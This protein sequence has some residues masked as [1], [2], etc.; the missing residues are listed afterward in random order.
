[1][2]IYDICCK[3]YFFR[4]ARIDADFGAAAAMTLLKQMMREAWTSVRVPVM[5][6]GVAVPGPFD[7]NSQRI[8]LMSGFP[9]WDRI[10]IQR[11]LAEEFGIPVFM[12]HDA[13]C[14]ALAEMWHG[15]HRMSNNLLYICADRGVGAGFILDGKIY[16]GRTGFAGEIGHTSINMFGPICECGN[17]GCLELYCST[18]ALEEEYRREGFSLT[19][20]PRT[21]VSRVTAK[22]ILRAVRGG[23]PL[24][25]R[26]YERV[27]SYLAFGA[28]NVVNSLNP[29]VLIFGDKMIEGGELFIE[30]ARKVLRNY[31]LPEVYDNLILDVSTLEGDPMLLGASVLVFEEL[32]NQPSQYFRGGQGAA[33]S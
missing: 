19:D 1:M 25:T 16:R 31:L 6:I 30:T 21:D 4:E 3:M 17:H 10:D 24:A 18:N 26:V 12:D 15:V 14:G 23:D 8:T 20:S 33:S 7:Y 11:E 9:G 32:L 29:E 22:D 27:V 2:A 13:K 5:G 28:V